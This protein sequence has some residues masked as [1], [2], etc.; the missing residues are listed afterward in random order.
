M[1]YRC[2]SPSTLIQW[3]PVKELKVDAP[4]QLRGRVSDPVESGEGIE[5]CRFERA[6][7]YFRSGLWNPVKELKGPSDGRLTATVLKWNPVK[8]LKVIFNALDCGRNIN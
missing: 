8:E 2:F 4:Q 5:S 6:K 3:N 7:A 1:T